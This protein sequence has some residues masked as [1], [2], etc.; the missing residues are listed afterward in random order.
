M[1]KIILTQAKILIAAV[2]LSD[3]IEQVTLSSIDDEVEVTSFG[4]TYH[5]LSLIHI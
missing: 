2:D 1:A 5:D 4:G 3:H